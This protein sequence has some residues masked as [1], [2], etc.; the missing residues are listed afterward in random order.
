M[1]KGG[2]SEQKR[3]HGVKRANEESQYANAVKI[4]AFQSIQ[5]I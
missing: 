4:L 5:V 2:E 1:K 3:V